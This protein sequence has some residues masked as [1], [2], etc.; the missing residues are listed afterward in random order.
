MVKK[1]LPEVWEFWSYEKWFFAE[2]A[3]MAMSNMWENIRFIGD[4]YQARPSKSLV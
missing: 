1:V 2:Q 3:E 4:A